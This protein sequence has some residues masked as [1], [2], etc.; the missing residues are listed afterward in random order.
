MVMWE[1]LQGSRLTWLAC[2]SISLTRAMP[3][4]T[5]LR[6]PPLSWML[7]VRRLSPSRNWLC[8]SQALIW[9]DSQPRPTTS[10]PQK[11]AWVA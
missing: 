10:T 2:G 9:L 4:S 3:F 1:A 6:V 8:A 7:N 11:L 5:V